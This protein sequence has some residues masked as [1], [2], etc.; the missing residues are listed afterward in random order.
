MSDETY[1]RDTVTLYS[2]EMLVTVEP[3]QVFVDGDGDIVGR[4]NHFGKPLGYGFHDYVP[5]DFQYCEA[6]VA[7]IRPTHNRAAV[8]DEWPANAP[9]S[10]RV[11]DLMEEPVRRPLLR[12]LWTTEPCERSTSDQELAEKAI[13]GLRQDIEDSRPVKSLDT[14]APAD[15]V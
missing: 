3:E 2:T 11:Y 12:F 8:S 1:L 14:T 6:V 10:K 7:H 9:K 5:Q 4:R 13:A 15:T